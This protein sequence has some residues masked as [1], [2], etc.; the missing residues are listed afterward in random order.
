PHSLGGTVGELRIH[1]DQVRRSPLEEIL[2]MALE[3][4]SVGAEVLPLRCRHLNDEFAVFDR[5]LPHERNGVESAAACRDLETVRCV[6]RGVIAKR[7]D[8]I[9][10][11]DIPAATQRGVAVE[12][13]L[14]VL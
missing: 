1:V 6:E 5:R 13:Q 7:F 4:E 2:V 11:T 12:M 14:L 10:G 8:E 3:E 9:A